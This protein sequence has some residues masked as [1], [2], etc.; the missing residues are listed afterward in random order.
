MTFD[1]EQSDPEIARRDLSRLEP[2]RLL[3]EPVMVV[4]S[5]FRSSTFRTRDLL[6]IDVDA[7]VPESWLPDGPADQVR[8][9]EPDEWSSRLDQLSD[10]EPEASV[11][12]SGAAVEVLLELTDLH[13]RGYFF[14]LSTRAPAQVVQEKLMRRV[15]DRGFMLADS[16]RSCAVINLNCFS[17]VHALP[18]P[19]PM[20]HRDLEASLAEL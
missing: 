17:V 13:G 10:S 16:E 5:K 9:L 7:P 4:S 2:A 6:R 3:R 8:E 11:L 20:D 14:E 1:F 19:P 15:F 18:G 12:R